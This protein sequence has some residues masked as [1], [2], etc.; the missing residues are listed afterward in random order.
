[1]SQWKKAGENLVRHWSGT[2]Y[3]RA[4]VAGKPIRISLQTD[5]I[6]IA[7]LKRD[8][9]LDALR[10]AAA[11]RNDQTIRTIGDALAVFA[12]E[13]AKP[14]LKASTVADYK[15]RIDYLRKTLPLQT[16]GRTWSEGEAAAWWKSVTGKLG[17]RLSN[18]LL[19]DAR[20]VMGILIRHGVRTS[21]PLARIKPMKPVTK[22]KQL[23]S[24]EQLQEI[25]HDIDV[26]G[27]PDSTQSARLV[28]FIA[29]S[30]C[31]PS[32]ALHITKSDIRGD[33]LAISGDETGTKTKTHRMIPINSH[34]RRTIDAILADLPAGQARLFT[35]ANPRFALLNA[36]RRLGLPHLSRYD[37]RHWFASWAIE[38]GV[39]IPTVALWMGHKDGGA[40]LMRTYAHMRDR[41][42]L[43]SA[44]KLTD[45][46]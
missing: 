29:F 39:D 20:K 4:K 33:W 27:M 5:D 26:Q 45:P 35:I 8:E 22:P 9:Q 28:A 17:A 16:H 38:R 24:L 2:I 40:L 43:D 32:E 19:H 11:Q 7:K 46:P 30:G 44:R 31:R 36:C 23:P 12:T 3:L 25:I 41:H 6:R 21:D 42:S 37:L 1:M 15:H 10:V 18:K 13:V 14:H 34:L